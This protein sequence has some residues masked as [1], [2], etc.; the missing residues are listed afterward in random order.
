M[1]GEVRMLPMTS[2]EQRLLEGGWTARRAQFEY[3][4]GDFSVPR[5]SWEASVQEK[6]HKVEGI[7]F[8]GKV[9]S[10]CSQTF[11]VAAIEGLCP[12]FHKKNQQLCSLVHEKREINERSHS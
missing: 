9:L 5:S 2:Q 4:A 3:S 11:G 10:Q 8:S 12:L 1:C 6:Q 7:H